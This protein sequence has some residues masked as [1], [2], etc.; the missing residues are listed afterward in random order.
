MIILNSIY[1]YRELNLGK[2]VRGIKRSTGLKQLSF[3]NELEKIIITQNDKKIIDISDIK[4]E[5]LYNKA[6]NISNFI[7]LKFDL[8]I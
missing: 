7:K 1:S 6:R 4:F 5:E 8:D 3:I 2:M